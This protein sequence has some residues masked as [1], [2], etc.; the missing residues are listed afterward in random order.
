MPIQFKYPDDP[1]RISAE[2]L[3]KLSTTYAPGRWLAQWKYD[4]WR[5]PIYKD[6]G[7]FKFYAK[8]STTSERDKPPPQHLID[9]L[10]AH[11]IPDGC[12]FDAEWMGPRDI[13]GIL[14]GKHYFVLFDMVYH[15]GDLLNDVR[16]DE[17]LKLLKQTVTPSELVQICETRAS[18]WD[19]MFEESKQDWLT[20]GIV[21][22]EAD[23]GLI[24]HPNASHDNPC[25]YKCK[26]RDIH[27]ATKF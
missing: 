15:E 23:S 24:A 27:E 21:L 6:A 16:F 14:N 9:A 1:V 13:K 7:E 5:C 22:R 10:H 11:N 4:G 3:K 26:W 2:Y 8:R 19:K 25:W 18:E 12:A 20:E 17:R